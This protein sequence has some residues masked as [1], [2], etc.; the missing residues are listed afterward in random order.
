TLSSGMTT[1]STAA[2]A[3]RPIHALVGSNV[4]RGSTSALRHVAATSGGS[5]AFIAGGRSWMRS[6]IDHPALEREQA[7]RALLDEHDDEHEQRDLREH[8]A[9]PR[10]EELVGDAEAQRRVHGAGEQ[11][12]AAQHDDHERIDDVALAEIGA[13]V[14]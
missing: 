11:A 7:L 12:D 10:L 4:R 3:T 9:R 6:R 2:A 14:A 5:G 1:T 13:D 8:R